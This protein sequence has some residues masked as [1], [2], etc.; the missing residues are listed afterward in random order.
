MTNSESFGTGTHGNSGGRL[1]RNVVERPIGDWLVEWGFITEKQLQVALHDS[2]THLLPVGMCLVLREQVDAETIQSAVGAQSYLRDGAITTQ[3]AA[4]AMT[5][6][7][8]KHVS[9]GIAFNLLAI[10]PEPIPRNRL[11]DLLSASRAISGGELKVVLTLAKATGLPLGRILLNHGSITE[12]LIQLALALQANIRR[13]EIDRNGAFEKLSQYVEDGARNS[14]LAGIG[15]HAE[16][17]TGCLL[18]KSGVIS[19]GNV[20]DAL[21]SGSK[22]GARLG[23]ILLG[24]G[25]IKQEMIDSTL[26][27]QKLIRAHKFTVPQ[28]LSVLRNV[29][30][31]Q[32]RD[33]IKSESG[34]HPQRHKPLVMSFYRYLKLTRA[35]PDVI[36]RGGSAQDPS[37]REAVQSEM[38]M[39]WQ[40]LRAVSPLAEPVVPSLPDDVRSLL[41]RCGFISDEQLVIA[42]RAAYTYKLALDQVLSIEQALI[43]FH[44]LKMEEGQP[45][46][47][48]GTFPNLSAI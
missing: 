7:K 4:N 46:D 23:E 35:L 36:S 29:H 40:E 12:D 20:K 26:E 9:L 11:G 19:E 2:R 27:V 42:Q 28:G 48:T 44:R 10:Q 6:V 14:I 31:A 5:L 45:K 21:N 16:T 39:T 18:V 47:W 38:E 3:E 43:E 32:R 13:G 1:D 25:V 15:L 33:E 24:K 34:Q 8:R 22:D 30:A 37:S 17:L 41:Q